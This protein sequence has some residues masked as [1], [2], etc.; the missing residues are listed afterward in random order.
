LFSVSLAHFLPI[1][2]YEIILPCV[3]EKEAMMTS[4][5]IIDDQPHM[6]ERISE[7]LRNM[8]CQIQS[9]RDI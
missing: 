6:P 3:C 4:V 1:P 2:E 5:L 8:G 7:E 9:V